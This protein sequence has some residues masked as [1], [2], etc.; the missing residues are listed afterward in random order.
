MVTYIVFAFHPPYPVLVVMFIIVGFG[1]GL[2]DGA[3][4]A[5]VGTM[6]NGNQSMGILQ[7]FYSLGATVSPLAAT[8]LF[9]KAGWQ[10]YEFYYIMVGL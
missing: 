9:S 3:W 1:N 2:I 7:A 4:S 8:S 10:W 6:A 5:W